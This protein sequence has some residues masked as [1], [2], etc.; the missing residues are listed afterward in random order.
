MG[1]CIAFFVF[2][3]GSDPLS[4]EFSSI[5]DISAMAVKDEG[6]EKL[7]KWTADK[8]VVLIVNVASE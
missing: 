7:S 2:K 5:N 3:K 6:P 4:S 1:A 8:K